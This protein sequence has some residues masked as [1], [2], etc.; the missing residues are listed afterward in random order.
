MDTSCVK[1]GTPGPRMR[2]SAGMAIA[3]MVRHLLKRQFSGLAGAGLPFASSTTSE[4]LHVR[5]TLP[6]MVTGQPYTV[7]A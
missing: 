7:K 6:I 2:L 3:E 4:D 1:D 5:R